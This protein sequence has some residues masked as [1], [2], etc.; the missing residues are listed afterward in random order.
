MVRVVNSRRKFARPS[1]RPSVNV[2]WA[3]SKHG[4]YTQAARLCASFLLLVVALRLLAPDLPRTLHILPVL[5]DQP[6]RS[7]QSGG[8]RYNASLPTAEY[9]R[10]VR[11]FLSTVPFAHFRSDRAAFLHSR[12][13]TFTCALVTIRSGR[14]SSVEWSAARQARKYRNNRALTHLRATLEA[15]LSPSSSS[16]SSSSRSSSPSSSQFSTLDPN[17]NLTFLVDLTNGS[18]GV[19]RPVALTLATARMWRGWTS[20]VPAPLALRPSTAPVVGWDA[21]A[22]AHRASWPR[23]PWSA[24]AGRAVFRGALRVCTFASGSCSFSNGARCSRARHWRECARGLLF[25]K[26]RRHAKTL[27]DV[28]F[29]SWGM[30]PARNF[31]QLD[32]APPAVERMPF[33]NFQRYKLVL[34]VGSNHDFSDRLR[35][36]L[37]LNSPVAHHVSEAV[38]FFTPLLQPWRHFVPLALDLS[39]AVPNVRK[40]LA[41]D[42]LL[43]AIRDSQAEFADRFLSESAMLEYWRILLREAAQRQSDADALL[44]EEIRAKAALPVVNM[45]HNHHLLHHRRSVAVSVA[46]VN[47]SALIEEEEGAQNLTAI[48]MRHNHHHRH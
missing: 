14:V 47:E 27:F 16:A 13:K 8:G 11:T 46:K 38:Q 42:R 17:L 18:V 40:A 20:A 23:F 36:L 5:A 21:T 3:P 1:D 32:G 6:V 34:D 43:C 12:N 48:N 37:F 26:A 30:H 4:A 9:T 31:H 39:D 15:A 33:R 29:T 35:A 10:V 7:R 24:K 28:A 41:D 44:A 2:A 45:R 19:R 25:A 22:A